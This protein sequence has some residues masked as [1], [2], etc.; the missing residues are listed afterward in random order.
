METTSEIES[1]FHCY[2]FCAYGKDFCKFCANL[3]I[4][5]IFSQQG[6][7]ILRLILPSLMCVYQFVC[8]CI[9]SSPNQYLALCFPSFYGHV[10]LFLPIIFPGSSFQIRYYCSMGISNQYMSRCDKFFITLSTCPN[11]RSGANGIHALV[12]MPLFLLEVTIKIHLAEFSML[13]NVLDVLHTS[14]NMFLDNHQ[15][16]GYLSPTMCLPTLFDWILC[17]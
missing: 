8:N 10:F 5:M 3:L 12:E 7:E 4:E 16:K 15:H 2:H 6:S 17:V 14:K 13:Y 1:R 11:I 9:E